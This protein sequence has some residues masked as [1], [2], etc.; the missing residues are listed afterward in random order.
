KTNP[1]IIDA[2]LRDMPHEIYTLPLAKTVWYFEDYAVCEKGGDSGLM[3]S[4]IEWSQTLDENGGI[5]LSK[6]AFLDT[7]SK[8]FSNAYDA[9]N[10]AAN[11]PADKKIH[12]NQEPIPWISS[13]PGLDQWFEK[14]FGPDSGFDPSKP[15]VPLPWEPYKPLPSR[16]A[17]SPYLPDW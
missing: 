8:N 12:K 15:V 1:T 10:N 5:T 14:T 11:G 13:I 9:W 4:G 7:P 6:P 2:E 17:P 3:Y 16:P